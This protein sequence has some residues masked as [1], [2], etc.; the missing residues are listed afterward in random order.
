[1]AT[2]D[3]KKVST[4][5]W[6]V[7]GGGAAVFIFSFLPWYGTSG[8]VAGLGISVNRSVSGW[9]S[10]LGILGILLCVAAAGFVLATRAF[11]LRSPQLPVGPALLAMGLAGL[12]TLFILIRLLS[13]DR[14]SLGG[15]SLGPK[16]GVFLALLAAIVETAAAFMLFRASGEKVSGTGPAAAAPP[17]A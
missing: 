12:G 10:F 2:F 3:A 7:I 6:A 9:D 13:Y 5:D 14:Q 16:I 1:M 15:I 11:A 8:S 4:Y 17:T